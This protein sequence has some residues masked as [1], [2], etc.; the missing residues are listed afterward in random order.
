MSQNGPKSFVLYT[1]IRPVL[2]LIPSEDGLPLLKAIFDYAAGE[3][4]EPFQNMVTDRIWE[5][6]R[7]KLEAGREKAAKRSETNR[8]NVQKRWDKESNTAVY[9]C[10]ESYTNE[11]HNRTEQVQDMNGTITEPLHVPVLNNDNTDSADAVFDSAG[12]RAAD[13]SAAGAAP[14]P[15]PDSDLFTIEQLNEIIL[16]NKIKMTKEDAAA[17]L[18]EM[19]ES[20]WMLYGK[21]VEKTFI[22]RALRGWAK[23]HGAAEVPDAEV[24]EL[25][26]V[27]RL[28]EKEMMKMFPNCKD[29][30][31]RGKEVFWAEG[32]KDLTGEATIHPDDRK[33]CSTW[34]DK[35]KSETYDTNRACIQIWDYF[36]QIMQTAYKY[37]DK[38]IL[39]DYDHMN[40]ILK[41][42]GKIPQKLQEWTDDMDVPD[43]LP[44][45]VPYKE[46][47]TEQR[48]FLYTAYNVRFPVGNVKLLNG[49]KG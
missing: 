45:F 35:N 21:P 16:R 19:H 28:T 30:D 6:I 36:D 17:F 9:D 3:D 29:W 13:A 26:D 47:T 24:P 49:H 12:G 8:K 48:R 7:Q 11:V 46:F 41:A 10:K 14:R 15:A 31:D 23:H 4:I 39:C 2:D 1:D 37:I 20:G 43:L 18:G 25:E 27:K 40:M 32:F 44:L 33:A 22:T 42:A 38:D 34:Y 5:M